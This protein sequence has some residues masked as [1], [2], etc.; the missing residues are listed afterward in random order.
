MIQ[1]DTP[2]KRKNSIISPKPN[3]DASKNK[4]RKNSVSPMTA[5]NLKKDKS[6]ENSKNITVKEEENE[7]SQQISKHNSSKT[8]INLYK[9]I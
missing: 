5:N 1:T 8:I 3:L 4:D 6:F 2:K 9:I 7:T